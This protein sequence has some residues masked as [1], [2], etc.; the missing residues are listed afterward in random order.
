M[1]KVNEK[2]WLL[3]EKKNDACSTKGKANST[4]EET[5]AFFLI[6]NLP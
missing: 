3:I 2:L 6:A 1:L 4:I 5:W